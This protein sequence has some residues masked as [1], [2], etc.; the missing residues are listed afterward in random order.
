MRP[1][2]YSQLRIENVEACRIT[3]DQQLLNNIKIGIGDVVKYELLINPLI[4]K[5]D[6][7]GYQSDI[8]RVLKG[9]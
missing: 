6:L 1:G 8:L 3:R 2:P 5:L 9:Q 4:I 7:K